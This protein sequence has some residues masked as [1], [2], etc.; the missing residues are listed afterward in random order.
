MEADTSGGWATAVAAVAT[1]GDG[2]LSWFQFKSAGKAVA[3]AQATKN[4]V[5]ANTGYDIVNAK[6]Y[7][8]LYIVGGG[9]ALLVVSIFVLRRD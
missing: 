2:V 7:T 5:A 8:G 6:D 9:L 1:L 3:R 4:Y